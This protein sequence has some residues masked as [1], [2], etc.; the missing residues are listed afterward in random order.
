[1]ASVDV[2]FFWHSVKHSPIGIYVVVSI[3]HI[4]YMPLDLGLEGGAASLD[5][6]RHIKYLPKNSTANAMFQ[7]A[8]VQ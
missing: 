6:R 3:P 1:M 5:L 2:S 4:P 7:R 8:I